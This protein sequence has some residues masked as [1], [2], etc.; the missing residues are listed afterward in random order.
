MDSTDPIWI[1]CKRLTPS[2]PIFYFPP[3]IFFRPALINSAPS[4]LFVADRLLEFDP[5]RFSLQNSLPHLSTEPW[6][7]CAFETFSSRLDYVRWG[8]YR[9]C[10]RQ[11]HHPRRFLQYPSP[12]LSGRAPL[13][14]VVFNADGCSARETHD[15]DVD[16]PG[17]H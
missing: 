17:S 2:F 8:P 4:V 9:P 13:Y 11:A 6:F 5:G 15:Q 14:G 12:L 16:G 3:F 7:G 1:K 10:L